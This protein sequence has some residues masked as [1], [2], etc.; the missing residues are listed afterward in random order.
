MSLDHCP[1]EIPRIREEEATPKWRHLVSPSCGHVR[2]T[3]EP[4]ARD[5]DAAE[6]VH[7]MLQCRRDVDAD[8]AP[9][10]TGDEGRDRSH[11]S[12]WR[13]SNGEPSRSTHDPAP[14]IPDDPLL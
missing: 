7:P 6:Q 12:V 9:R 8:G 10:L 14:G 1:P 11:S 2:G 3:S 4:P 5:A 13:A